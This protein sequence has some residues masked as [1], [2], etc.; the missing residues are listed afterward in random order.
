MTTKPSND[1]QDAEIELVQT[2]GTIAIH[3]REPIRRAVI[4]AAEYSDTRLANAHEQLENTERKIRALY[5]QH[6]HELR[7]HG[8]AIAKAEQ[9][10]R[11]ADE[12][13][14]IV[15]TSE[16]RLRAI[17]QELRALSVQLYTTES[18]RR[19]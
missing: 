1:V 5:E 16:V 4:V 13:Q 19:G 7:V 14:A 18:V 11:R 15:K 2:G 12:C 6:E 3:T 10:R 9:T 8:Q 17:E